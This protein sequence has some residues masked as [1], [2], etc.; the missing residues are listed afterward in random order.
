MPSTHKSLSC[1]LQLLC[2]GNNVTGQG[3]GIS[4]EG[5]R[6]GRLLS[7]SHTECLLE[8]LPENF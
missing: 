4:R 5:L 6:E 7:H 8:Q 1:P 3:P 2:E